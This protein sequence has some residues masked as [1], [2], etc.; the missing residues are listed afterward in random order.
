MKRLS[1]V[2]AS[3]AVVAAAMSL[4]LQRSRTRAQDA[5]PQL[6]LSDGEHSAHIFPTV[7]GAGA[8][9][10]MGTLS[11]PL[12][13]NGGP[14]MT[15]SVT[16]YAIFWLPASGTLQN[17]NPTSMS[18][19][20]Q[21]VQKNLFG[22]YPGHGIDNNNT[23]Y[24]Q[25]SGGV[26]SFLQNKGSLGGSYVDTSAYPASGCNDSATPGNC[27]TDAQI[28]AEIQHVMTLK[29]WTGAINKMFLLFT[30]SGEGSCFDSSSTSCAYTQ[31]CA[32]HSYFLSGTTP[33]IYGNEPY[34]DTTYCQVPGTPSPNGDAAA[35]TA[36]TAASHEL[37]EAIT[38]P[39]IN[40]WLTAQG[41][42]IG[43]LCA[44]NYGV[45]TWDSGQ[46]NEMWNGR[47]YE[48]QMEYDNHTGSC[49]QLGP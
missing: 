16:T 40:A 26:K 34:G 4:L 45:N 14:V 39:E 48:L 35:D 10:Q 41:Y 20:Y 5:P 28:Q 12:L 30:S 27:I 36:A 9:R 29:G 6:T 17:G 2:V 43:D 38:D 18:A 33:V 11:G 21:T 15:G 7:A 23:Q 37:T 31:Y 49:L 3:I 1:T 24:Y 22:D 44:Y 13:Y 47:F 32:Y 42:E 8:H 25:I 19:H 46:A